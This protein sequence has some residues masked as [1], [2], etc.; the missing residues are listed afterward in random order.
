[1]WLPVRVVTGDDDIAV[2]EASGKG[3][4][5]A[6]DWQPLSYG[7]RDLVK[8]DKANDDRFDA[9]KSF[10]QI[11]RR[12]DPAILDRIWK[13]SQAVW[14]NRDRRISENLEFFTA[15]D[16]RHNA[17]S[18]KSTTESLSAC[19]MCE[20]ICQYKFV[21][22]KD[23]I[24]F[25][26][27]FGDHDLW[28]QSFPPVYM[29]QIGLNLLQGDEKNKLTTDIA[30]ILTKANDSA[31]WSL[32]FPKLSIKV[33]GVALED[34]EFEWPNVSK[35]YAKWLLRKYRLPQIHSAKVGSTVTL[36]IEYE[37]VV[38]SSLPYFVF[39]APWVVHRAKVQIIVRGDF[40]YFV[41]SIRLV[42]PGSAEQREAEA[43][44]QRE[45]SFSYQNIML[46]G[47]AM[48]VYWQKKL[49]QENDKTKESA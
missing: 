36:R 31:I 33:D 13:A 15:I 35:R 41:P 16:L 9:A 30:E 22:E 12:T 4:Y 21:L 20:T 1:M 19:G 5:G 3:V 23:H 48:E 10:L 29:H 14:N 27:S 38:P 17:T 7:H 43:H 25:G 39:S 28:K 45:V 42:P 47:S 46:P 32:F 6:I 49:P 37:S 44:E 40:E 26:I 11:C 34:G 8:P 2:K 24:E 18:L